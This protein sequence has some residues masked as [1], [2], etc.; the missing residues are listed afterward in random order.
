MSKPVAIIP[1][2]GIGTRLR[3]HTYSVPKAL[4][5]VAGKPILGHILDRLMARGIERCIVVTGYMGERVRE[6]LAEHY[7]RGVE[8]VEQRRRLGLGHAVAQTA[9]VLPEGPAL[10]ILGDTIV[11]P[12]WDDY[13]GG[14]EGVI[15]VRAVEDARRFGVVEISGQRVRR[16]I[17]KPA[18]PPSNLVIVGI[19]YFPDVAPLHAALRDLM[20]DDQR[21]R[22]E[23]QLTDALQRLIEQG[24]PMRVSRVGGW[25][26][27]GTTETLLETNRHLL[28]D[29]PPP[30][31]RPRVTLVPPVRVAPS[32][33]LQNA[34]VGPNVS[35]ADGAVVRDAVIRESIVNVGA[36]VEALLMENSVIGEAAL[37][38]GSFQQLN[39][40]DNSAVDSRR[41]E[42][43]N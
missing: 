23:Y 29:A 18:D 6:Y 26:D 42:P 40:G 16:L 39:V 30:E 10:V 31:P 24:V 32:A 43:G 5:H 17:E 2:A 13:L 21:T 12:D 9:E 34:V 35:I 4:L 11:E 41:G 33:E 14:A 7:P 3:P 15:G 25:F 36:R 27:C 38:R 8:I 1:A 22:G 20:Q 19:Y 37:V 28:Q